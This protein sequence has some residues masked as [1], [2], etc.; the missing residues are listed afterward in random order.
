MKSHQGVVSKG[1]RPFA[2]SNGWFIIQVVRGWFLISICTQGQV[3]YRRRN[4]G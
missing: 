1:R 4:R 2:E 3:G